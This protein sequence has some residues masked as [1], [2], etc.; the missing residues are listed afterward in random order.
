MIR[1]PHSQKDRY[2]SRSERLADDHQ[3]GLWA[4]RGTYGPGAT[5]AGG[6]D[7][8][9]NAVATLSAGYVLAE[10]IGKGAVQM[11]VQVLGSEDAPAIVRV[12]LQF[13]LSGSGL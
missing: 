13:L 4:G 2:R 7:V 9:G 8:A 6:F 1:M 3:P 11:I 12:E 10:Q 5:T